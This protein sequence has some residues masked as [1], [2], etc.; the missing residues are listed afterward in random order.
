MEELYV[1]FLL[2][3]YKLNTRERYNGLLN[4]LFLLETNN[5]FLLKLEWCSTNVIE[6][7]RCFA[8]YMNYKQ[9]NIDSNKFGRYLINGLNSVYKSN[10]MSIEDFGKRCYLLWK[11]LPDQLSNIEPF[12]VLSYADEPL[13]WGDE[14]QA[15]NIYETVFKYYD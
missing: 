5:D 10:I 4:D 15:R 9:Q 3:K 8:Y 7:D 11:D 1:E 12:I 2:W 6:T 14:A 13:S